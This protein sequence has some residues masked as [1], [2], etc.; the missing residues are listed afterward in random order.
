MSD[1]TVSSDGVGRLGGGEAELLNL[2]D[3]CRQKIVTGTTDTMQ[4]VTWAG[5]G[6]EET[7]EFGCRVKGTR[8]APGFEHAWRCD[9][10]DDRLQLLFCC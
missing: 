9:K 3:P 10:E 1:V 2:V 4:E 8:V 7:R 5:T 6:L